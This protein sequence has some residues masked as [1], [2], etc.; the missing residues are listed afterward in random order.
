MIANR[1][2]RPYADARTNSVQGRRIAAEYLAA[3]SYDRN[4]EDA[5]R[6]FRDETVRQYEELSTLGLAL[7]VTPDDPYADYA[8]LAQ[9]IESGTFRV[10]ATESTGGHPFLPNAV[11][12]MFRFVHDFH[13][14]YMSGRD[15]SRHGEHAAWLRHSSM[16]S[17]LARLAMTTETRGQNSTF[18]YAFA[19][20]TFPE[21]KVIT[22]PEWVTE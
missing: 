14:H 2:I 1:D 3:P 5:Y 6:A 22:L 18:I 20:Q 8:E 7:E 12:D 11:N 9:S 21:Q 4:A 17:P 19:G 15:F 13:G 10:L 16:Y